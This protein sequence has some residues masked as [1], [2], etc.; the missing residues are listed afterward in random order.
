VK[1]VPVSGSNKILVLTEDEDFIK[2]LQATR[3]GSSRP[4]VTVTILRHNG[5]SQALRELARTMAKELITVSPPVLKEPF[6]V[7][8]AAP[9]RARHKKGKR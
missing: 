9:G 2:V 1:G 4:Y 6:W 8:R 7:D 3:T 5:K